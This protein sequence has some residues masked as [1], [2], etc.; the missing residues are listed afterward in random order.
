MNMHVKVDIK[1]IRMEQCLI[2]L[3]FLLLSL[4]SY[5]QKKVYLDKLRQPTDKKSAVFVKKYIKENDKLYYQI[6]Q[7]AGKK[8]IFEA[9]LCTAD[10]EVKEGSAKEWNTN[11]ILI[12]SGYFSANKKS[13]IWKTYYGNKSPESVY[14]IKEDSYLYHQIWDKYEKPQLKNG[15]G[16]ITKKLKG[17]T[18]E[19]RYEYKDS[20]LL[21]TYFI[22][23]FSDTVY[24]NPINKATYK[25]GRKHLYDFLGNI[26]IYPINALK[27][28]VSE[29]VYLRFQVNIDGTIGK[30]VVTNGLGLGCDEEAIRVLSLTSGQWLPAHFNHYPVNSIVELPVRFLMEKRTK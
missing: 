26:V 21:R 4:Q 25:N 24:Y 3:L 13:G 1:S 30:I 22:D 6:Y 27:L 15:N 2:I 17:F 14:S 28:G 7:L 23:N 20:L 8:L 19:L 9:Q 12:T 11:G 18:D 29:N 10:P 5:S 16:I